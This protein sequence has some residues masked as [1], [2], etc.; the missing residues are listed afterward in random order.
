MAP[1][2][3]IIISI[4]KYFIIKLIKV[5]IYIYIYIFVKTSLL[6]LLLL[7]FYFNETSPKVSNHATTN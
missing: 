1:I 7:L 2:K 6:L 4:C 5:L 3:F